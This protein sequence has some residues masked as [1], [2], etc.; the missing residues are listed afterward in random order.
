M[1]K[2][3]LQSKIADILTIRPVSSQQDADSIRQQMAAELASAIDKYVQAQ[4]GER[5]AL[6]TT[7]IT[8]P[9]PAGVPVPAP[10][11]PQFSRIV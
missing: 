11:F 1:N 6:I 9:S 10:G 2:I 3:E 4:I 8:C 5:L 7:A